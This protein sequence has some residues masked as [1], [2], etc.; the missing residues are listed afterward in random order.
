MDMVIFATKL[1][2]KGDT[3]SHRLSISP[4][5]YSFHLRLFITRDLRISPF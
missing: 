1:T 3:I 2:T 4:T 5:T